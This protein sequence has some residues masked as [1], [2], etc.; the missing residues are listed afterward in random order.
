[1]PK[2]TPLT[3]RKIIRILERKGFILD[4]V[5]GS[6]HIYFHPETKRR[7]IVPMHKRDLPNRDIT[8]YSGT[9]GY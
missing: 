6:H 3:P 9:G 1:M 5:R 2:L 7:A 4:R 8:I